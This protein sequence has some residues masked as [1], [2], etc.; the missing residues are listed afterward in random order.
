MFLLPGFNA[1]IFQILIICQL[2]NRY[3]CCRTG[4]CPHYPEAMK[5][6]AD[7]KKKEAADKKTAADAKKAEAAQKRVEAVA[8]QADM[9]AKRAK[10]QQTRDG[11]VANITDGKAKRKAGMLADAAIAGKPIQRVKANFTAANETQACD[12]AYAAMKLNSSIGVCEVTNAT[13]SRRRGLLATDA[14][15]LVSLLLSETEIDNNTIAA[16]LNALAAANISVATVVE[17]ALTL[18]ATVDGV[19]SSTLAIITSEATVRF[20]SVMLRPWHHH[21]TDEPGSL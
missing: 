20:V 13:S 21:I 3:N 4:Y 17:E 15:Y 18:L 5:D 14:E 9:A 10:A 19:D 8:K 1:R 12:N 11:M 16:A 2:L 6:A 7:V